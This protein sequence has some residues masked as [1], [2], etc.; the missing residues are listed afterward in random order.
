MTHEGKSLFR[1]F[2]EGAALDPRFANIRVEDLY[3]PLR[4][5]MDS[6]YADFEDSDGNFLEQFQTAGFDARFFEFYLYAYFTKCGFALER[7]HPNPDFIIERG[8]CRVAVE[9]TTVNPAQSGAVH[10]YGRRLS[11]INTS[12]EYDDFFFNEMCIRYG[13][14][15]TAKLNKRYWENA[16]CRGL[17]LV[18]AIED[19][20]EAEAIGL[21]DASLVAYLYGRRT[22]GSYDE[23]GKQQ[24][25]VDPL[26]QH[27]L[28]GGK[29][30]PSSFFNLPFSKNISAVIFTNAGTIT[31][32]WRMGYQEG[33]GNGT[34]SLFRFGRYFSL[35][36]F[37]N[38][39]SFFG[40]DMDNP[41]FAE[42]WG[43]GCTLY[44]NPRALIPLPKGFFPGLM[45][46][47]PSDDF[48]TFSCSFT[49]IEH[50]QPFSSRTV[51]VPVDGDRK[52]EL[53]AKNK[54][55]FPSFFIRAVTKTEFHSATQ[56][57]HKPRN[58]MIEQG[59]FKEGPHEVFFG[60]I[61]FNEATSKWDTTLYAKDSAGMMHKGAEKLDMD[62][63]R[64]ALSAIFIPTM[65]K[66]IECSSPQDLAAFLSLGI[67]QA[68]V[69]IPQ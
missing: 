37:D 68:Y 17:P 47:H 1:L 38:Q 4:A 60:V 9:A 3:I 10:Q 12:R 42:E 52:N 16:N 6:I 66:I 19:F 14:P 55:A 56:A 48:S 45:E 34:N 32:F 41:P 57:I 15:L 27:R 69:K 18:L 31:K 49:S 61:S 63:K 53:A 36:E 35:G 54:A 51:I 23:D 64:E 24:V 22:S 21:T 39:P 67:L 13:G 62:D 2:G 11:D 59:W 30:I 26:E 65:L 50:F 7:P 29:V 40:Y 20:H 44:R 8:G 43:Q 58:G 25:Q 46:N 33:Y 5:Y 28:A